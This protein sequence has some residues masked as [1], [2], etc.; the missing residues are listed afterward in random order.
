MAID[1]TGIIDSDLAHDVYNEILDLYDTGIY[2]TEIRTR[3]S[4][5]EDALTDDLDLEIYLAACV[6]AFWEIGKLDGMLTTR[7]TQL[8]ERGSSLALWAEDGNTQIAKERKTKL[9]RLL[10]QVSKPRLKPRPRKKYSKIKTK[11]FSIGD[12]LELV[13]DGKIFRGVM[14]H[15]Q[16]YRGECDYSILV[17]SPETESNIDSFSAG[18]YYGHYIGSDKGKILG[19]HVIRPEHR[20][21]VRANNPFRVI[22]H[23]PLD[24]TKFM[25][26]SYTGVLEM[27][28]VIK[29]F[30]RTINDAPAFGRSLFPLNELLSDNIGDKL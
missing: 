5:C 13:A 15:I 6:K 12:C 20:M 14:C 11:L 19:P 25:L 8:L 26:G 10:R 17:M 16:E 2:V 1:G 3:I 4:E 22:G 30:E 21:L 18:Y 23:L 24:E 28:H 29:E 7:L 27:S 9:S